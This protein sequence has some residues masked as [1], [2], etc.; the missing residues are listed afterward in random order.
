MNM[1][2]LADIKIQD[3]KSAGGRKSNQSRSKGHVY[4]YVDVAREYKKDIKDIDPKKV[5]VKFNDMTDRKQITRVG[6]VN[7]AGLK[8]ECVKIVSFEGAKDVVLKSE[9]M[10][11]GRL[12][13]VV[14]DKLE[15][16]K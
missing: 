9:E 2:K 7:M 3:R 10:R 5:I 13:K 4:K 1:K 8:I 14:G 15:Q 16:V 12:F 6:F 11:K